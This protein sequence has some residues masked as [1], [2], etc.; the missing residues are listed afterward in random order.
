MVVRVK[1]KPALLRWARKRAGFEQDQL[2]KTKKFKKLREW[3][4]G[5]L[6][7][8]LGQL[9]EFAKKVHIP[10]G[11]LFLPEPPVE[12]LP[13]SDFRTVGP[14]RLT[15]NLL[16]TIYM[17]QN[18]QYWYRGFARSENEPERHFVG[19][20]NTTMLPSD[21]AQDMRKVLGFSLKAQRKCKT[22]SDTLRK[23]GRHAEEAGVLVMKGRF[24]GNNYRRPLKTGEFRGFALADALAP[25]VFIN[26]ADAKV[27]QMFTLTHELAHIWLG[28]SGLSNIDRSSTGL[29][30]G[31]QEDWCDKVAAEFLVPQDALL[32]ELGQ[33]TSYTPQ[34]LA[35]L[36]RVFKVSKLVVLRRLLDTNCLDYDMFER[37]WEE[38]MEAV[39]YRRQ[40]RKQKKTRGDFYLTSLSRT[41]YR[42]AHAVITSTLEG[43]TLY[44]DAY[45]MLGVSKAKT[46]DRMCTEIITLTT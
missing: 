7:P 8:T 24:V 37:F 43:R 32:A 1:I 14:P 26:T 46:F 27:A 31:H 28:V 23:F 3:E 41:G 33:M 2:T 13:I 5:E 18:R 19:S 29:L 25:L 22:W 21:V 34:T 9:E 15:P 10:I 20:A 30:Q 6:R 12:R 11:V 42:F 39:R 40:Q 16:D 45:Q 36:A 17:C 38:E 44:G 4:A 35:R